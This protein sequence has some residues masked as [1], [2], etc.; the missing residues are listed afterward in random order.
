MNH[1]STVTTVLGMISG[2]SHDGIDAAVVDFRTAGDGVLDGVGTAIGEEDLVQLARGAFGPPRPELWEW[3]PQ[4]LRQ[5]R[6]PENT[7]VQ[8]QK[9]RSEPP[10]NNPFAAL[11]GLV[12]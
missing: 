10:A 3:R 8:Q 4:H 7:R 11:A 9:P 2:T 1:T 5:P 6:Q 12:R